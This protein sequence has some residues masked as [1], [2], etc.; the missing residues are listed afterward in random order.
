MRLICGQWI[1]AANLQSEDVM[2]LLDNSSYEEIRFIL[3]RYLIYRHVYL[4]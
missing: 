4:Y 2:L 1:K 3:G